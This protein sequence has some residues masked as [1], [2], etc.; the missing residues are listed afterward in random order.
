MGLSHPPTLKICHFA[1]QKR[2]YNVFLQDN[3][4]DLGPI[5]QLLLLKTCTS[6]SLI[7]VGQKTYD[8]PSKIY[9]CYVPAYSK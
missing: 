1:E 7:F 3:V 5:D 9:L 8:T 4:L 2:Q 6:K